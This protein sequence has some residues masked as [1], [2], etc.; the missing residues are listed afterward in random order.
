M[1]PFSIIPKNGNNEI[2][3]L[4]NKKQVLQKYNISSM[5]LEKWKNEGLQYYKFGQSKTSMIKYKKKHLDDFVE[6]HLV[7]L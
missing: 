1:E 6:K 7:T 2:D 3:I 5:T 4:Y